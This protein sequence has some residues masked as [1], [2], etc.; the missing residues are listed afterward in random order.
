VVVAKDVPVDDLKNVVEFIYNGEVNVDTE[1]LES[2][3]KT[4][5]MLGIAGL[6]ISDRA[7]RRLD[8]NGDRLNG[9]PGAPGQTGNFTIATDGTGDTQQTRHRK[10][11][12]SMPKKVSLEPSRLVTRRLRG[13]PF[14]FVDFNVFFCSISEK[15]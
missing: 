15:S 10:R 2:F 3:F 13:M 1:C 5:Q 12:S 9:G 11:K 4:A 8:A 6:K 7:G 14:H